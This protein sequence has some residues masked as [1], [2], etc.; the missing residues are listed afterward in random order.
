MSQESVGIGPVELATAYRGPHKAL[1]SPILPGIS[2][3]KPPP[4]HHRAYHVSMTIRDR[5]AAAAAV[6][7]RQ[8]GDPQ[9]VHLR[10]VDAIQLQY[11]LLAEGGEVGHAIMQGGIGKAVS[12]ICGLQI[13][14]KSAQFSV[15]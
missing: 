1:C 7:R 12:R 13:V 2:G 4:P 6:V 11:E 5:I 8:G 15:V 9:Q 3:L 14:W 10:P